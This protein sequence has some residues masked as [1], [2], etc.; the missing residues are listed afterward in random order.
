MIDKQTLTIQSNNEFSIIAQNSAYLWPSLKSCRS[1]SMLGMD[2]YGLP[3]RVIISQHKIPKLQTSDYRAKMRQIE[4]WVIF[5]S[6][7]TYFI[8]SFLLMYSTVFFQFSFSTLVIRHFCSFALHDYFFES[9]KKRWIANKYLKF[10]IQ[11][12]IHL[13]VYLSILLPILS[14]FL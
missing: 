1:F 13:G 4:F 9:Q 2:G 14:I 7:V 11:L 3:P 8:T 10:D 6:L 5:S 12:S